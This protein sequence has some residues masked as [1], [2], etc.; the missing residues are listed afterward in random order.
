MW[1]F[2]LTKELLTFTY[3]WFWTASFGKARIL[4]RHSLCISKLIPFKSSLIFKSAFRKESLIQDYLL[5]WRSCLICQDS[6]FHLW[7]WPYA[8]PCCPPR[9]KA[10][11]LWDKVWLRLVSQQGAVVNSVSAGSLYQDASSFFSVFLGEVISLLFFWCCFFAGECRVSSVGR[12]SGVIS[13]IVC[14]ICRWQKTDW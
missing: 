11:T 8:L 5:L 13:G 3:F 4:E 7:L 14:S 1:D 9:V 6:I 12:K 10:L 2:P